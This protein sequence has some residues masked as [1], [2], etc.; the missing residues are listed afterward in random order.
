[1]HATTQYPGTQGFWETCEQT[2]FFAYKSSTSCLRLKQIHKIIDQESDA[3]YDE[4]IEE[5]PQWQEELERLQKLR[6]AQV[7]HDTLRAKDIPNLEEQIKEQ[8]SLHPEISLEVEQVCI[9]WSFLACFLYPFQISEKLEVINVQLRDILTLKQQASNI[10]RL[11]KEM[12]RA[13]QEIS[14][15]ENNLLSTGSTK[16]ADDVQNDLGQI[17]EQ[18]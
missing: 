15:L 10:G 5:L 11:Q 1:M 16:T 2:F 6:P 17:T 7:T 13:K 3:N 9:Y 4:L 8:E 14:Q 12:E 18:M